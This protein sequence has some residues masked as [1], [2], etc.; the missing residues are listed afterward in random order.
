MVLERGGHS[1]HPQCRRRK[2]LLQQSSRSRSK[3]WQQHISVFINTFKGENLQGLQFLYHDVCAKWLC[4]CASMY[5]PDPCNLWHAHHSWQRPQHST[6][7]HMAPVSWFRTNIGSQD[8]WPLSKST[9]H[10]RKQDSTSA[11]SSRYIR[12]L[13]IAVNIS[14][15]FHS[16]LCG[17]NSVS[18]QCV[19][20]NQH[21][22]VQGCV[23]WVVLC[24]QFLE[25]MQDYDWVTKKIDPTSIISSVSILVINCTT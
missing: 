8:C 5:A 19:C 10:L 20:A 3:G 12:T 21:G 24:R 13:D 14:D 6:V 17:T 15:W 4:T 9:T 18:M 11:C 1:G 23:Q 22:A 25:I 7:F 2:G 16:Y